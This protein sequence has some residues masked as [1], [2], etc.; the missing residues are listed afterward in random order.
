MIKTPFYFR[1][2]AFCFL[3]KIRELYSVIDICFLCDCY[4]S[5]MRY[6]CFRNI[7]FDLTNV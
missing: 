1:K 6:F 4:L 7:H 3:L 5:K 2:T